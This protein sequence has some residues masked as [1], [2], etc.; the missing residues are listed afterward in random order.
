MMATDEEVN[1]INLL[2]NEIDEELDIKTKWKDTMVKRLGMY[3]EKLYTKL[4]MMDILYFY[5]GYQVFYTSLD[6]CK[7]LL[8]EFTF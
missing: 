1:F 7:E 8:K 4:K 6:R 2:E 3:K 5:D